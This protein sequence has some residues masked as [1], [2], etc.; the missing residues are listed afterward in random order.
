MKDYSLPSLCE[1]SHKDGGGGRD[2][3][4]LVL[5]SGIVSKGNGD[6]FLT[7]ESHTSLTKGGG[8]AGQ[9][10]PCIL[11]A[12]FS[13]GAAPTAGGIGYQEEC[14]PTLKASESGTNMVP[15][16]LFSISTSVS[17]AALNTS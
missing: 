4:G 2:P 7:P 10:Y 12:G 8:Q 5:A 11:T 13:A 1:D 6:C 14:S 17:K 9:G 3:A 15:S 16:V